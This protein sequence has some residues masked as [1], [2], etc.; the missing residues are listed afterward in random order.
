MSLEEVT[1]AAD[2]IR[3]AVESDRVNSS[4]SFASRSRP[5]TGCRRWSTTRW[6][7]RAADDW[8]VLNGFLSRG[9]C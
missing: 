7:A 9:S 3:T 5:A 2:Q 1:A 6:I 8:G 4:P